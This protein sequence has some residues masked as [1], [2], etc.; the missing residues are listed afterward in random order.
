MVQTWERAWSEALYGPAGFYRRPEGP[1]GHFGTSAQG[2]GADLLAEAL[3]ELARRESLTTVVDV[4]CGRGELLRSLAAQAD[5]S[6]TLIG[7]DVVERPVDLPERV[8]WVTSPGGRDLPDLGS[9]TDALVLAH[10]WLDVVPCHIAQADPAG[11]LCTVLVE[12]DG[13]E[14]LGDRLTAADL[15]WA[16]RW[17]P[18]PH[19]PDDRVEIGRTRDEAFSSLVGRMGS[20]LLIAVD[21]AHTRDDRPPTGTLI[22]FAEG[23]V[24]PPVP[25]GSCDITAHVAMDSL[26]ADAVL[27][28][29]V[30]LR[31]LGID[32][33]R[34]PIETAR[35]DPAGYL[36]ALSRASV[37]ASLTG[38]GAGDFLWALRRVG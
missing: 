1:A 6:V 7:C 27:T 18:G 14:R 29:R 4:A 34:P 31:D 16:D 37:A 24:C 30:I 26:D 25:D 38:P 5:S 23:Q 22:G 35:T 17:W 36:A 32:G 20:G 11:V 33:S 21:Y 10:E 15:E 2:S 12:P 8:R 28:Q 13:T 3:L 9:P 19:S